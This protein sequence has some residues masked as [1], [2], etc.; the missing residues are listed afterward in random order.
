[1]KLPR[2]TV[3]FT[4]TRKTFPVGCNG[5][6]RDVLFDTLLKTLRRAA[7][8]QTITVA[9]KQVNKIATMMGRQRVVLRRWQEL[10]GCKNN[11]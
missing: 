10:S 5:E 2:R 7:N 6:F 1:M 8:V 4:P 11:T 9:H 3:G